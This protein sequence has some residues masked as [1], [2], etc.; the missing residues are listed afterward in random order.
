MPPP[1]FLARPSAGR[2]FE[3]FV[4]AV[5][6]PA[7]ADGFVAL[8]QS[9]LDHGAATRNGS[10][11]HPLLDLIESD[12][13]T[14]DGFGAALTALLSD[15]DPTNLVGVAGIPG[16]RGFFSEF[17]D[18]F[19]NHLLPAPRDERD[20]RP[21]V[22]RLYRT[23]RDVRA[24]GE[25][26]LDLFHRLT[27]A[28]ASVPPPDAWT[29][30]CAT[31]ADSFRLLLTRVESEGLSPKLRTRA[32]RSSVSASPFHR[33][34]VAGD[35][36]LAVWLA[37]ADVADAADC[38]RKLSGECR[39]EIRVIQQQLDGAGVSVD[40]VFSLE[41]I[42]RCLTRMALMTDIMESP[43]DVRRS[44]AIHR[45]LFR[46]VLSAHQDRSL[47]HLVGW[48]M[49][50]LGRKIVERSSETGEHYI[51]RTLHEYRHIWLAAA[52][53]GALT[54]GTAVVKSVIHRWHLPELPEGLLYGLNYAASFVVMQ[55]LGLILAT[56]QPAMTA[57]RL[58]TMIRESEG[59]DRENR[60]AVTASLLTS[61]Q[62]AA[63]VANVVVVAAGAALFSWL[64]LALAGR[65][66][67]DET[68]AA[69]TLQVMSPVNSLTIWYAALTG[70]LLWLASVVG[71]WFGNWCVYHRIPDGIA[72]GP[73]ATMWGRRL[74]QRFGA[75]LSHHAA[76]WG[77][78]VSLGFMLGMA[79]EIYRVTGLPVDVRHVTLN[80]G[81]VSV[82]TAS[83]GFES[84][85]VAR[86]LLALSGIAVMFVLNLSV[87]F[88]CS[89]FSASRAY[90]LPASEV[91][92]IL[93][94]I[95]R[96]LKRSPLS[97]VRPPR[98]E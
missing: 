43:A 37:G 76:A 31:F 6:A 46:V 24:L 52:G 69:D 16:N 47:R 71:G 49:Q 61:S 41:V 44:R 95:G 81:M 63:A 62:L 88:A 18:R 57:A 48:N 3:A 72:Q 55:H 15:I 12:G 35:A 29:G 74:R 65:P 96:R 2:A 38:F 89:L 66:F 20:V 45:L 9:I 84:H 10:T 85:M 80:T 30:L 21:L 87:S 94:G 7:R 56:K 1:L 51:A 34:A 8:F 86:L 33:V 14:R 79:P 25:L 53:G 5:D 58:A 4:S 90:Q 91:L 70:V 83:L 40:I 77:T 60:I 82:A 26:P 97:F 42:E 22:H 27:A 11:V 64:F 75:A 19:A 59:E 32:T 17:G 78:N 73:A 23:E 92:G 28:M 39:K 68:E 67:L 36:L 13:K 50:L 54:V 93:Q 98:S